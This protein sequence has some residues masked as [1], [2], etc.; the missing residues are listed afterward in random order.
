MA[1]FAYSDK[2]AAQALT[3][4]IGTSRWATVAF[5]HGYLA[6]QDGKDED[7]A[8]RIIF[9]KGPQTLKRSRE[10]IEQSKSLG[11]FTL[12]EERKKTGSAENP[13]TKLFPATITEQRFLELLDELCDDQSNL[14]YSD[15]RDTRSLTD[16]VLKKGE[17][18]LPINVKNAGTRFERAQDLV[19]LDPNDCLP[20][21]AYKAH[22][23]L[24]V[25]LNLLYVISVDYAL[26]DNLV[27]QQ[28]NFGMI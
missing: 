14:T 9:E 26:L 22:A 17:D 7:S 11:F 20:I 4:I 23:A 5:A 18:E 13:I 21:P 3:G 2:E 10:L 19:G 15:D 27:S 24:E 8:A 1:D 16:F 28:L 6:L 12:L 25:S